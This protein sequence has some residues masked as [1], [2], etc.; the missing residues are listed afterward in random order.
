M[1]HKFFLE[2]VK[3]YAKFTNISNQA[4]TETQPYGYKNA[5]SQRAGFN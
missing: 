4:E 5:W 3:F 2:S 1:E